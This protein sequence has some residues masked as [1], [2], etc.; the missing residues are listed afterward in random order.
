MVA[1]SSWRSELPSMASSLYQV[2][3]R[4]ADVNEASC[5]AIVLAVYNYGTSLRRCY[6]FV[7][8]NIDIYNVQYIP[9]IY[10][11][12]TYYAY[13]QNSFLFEKLIINHRIVGTLRATQVAI[14]LKE[15][16]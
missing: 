6:V 2:P 9:D 10:R 4:K 1:P 7:L 14:L 8:S 16:R 3:A 13:P 11:I 12:Y 15:F 5:T